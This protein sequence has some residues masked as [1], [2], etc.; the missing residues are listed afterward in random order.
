MDGYVSKPVDEKRLLEVIEEHQALIPAPPPAS[1]PP[2]AAPEDTEHP[3]NLRA[4][5]ALIDGDRAF[6]EEV[7]VLYRA[8]S[9]ALI[10]AIRQ[11][12]AQGDLARVGHPAHNLKNWV[13]SFAAQRAVL[14]TRQLEESAQAGNLDQA[15]AAFVRLEPILVRLDDALARLATDGPVAAHS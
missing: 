10:D 7:A 5:L 2:P 8:Q 4:A 15:R 11:A 12:L 1:A 3:M 9:P 13:Y 14:A 6:L